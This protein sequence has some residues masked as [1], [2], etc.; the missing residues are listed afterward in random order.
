MNLLEEVH[1]RAMNI[2]RGLELLSCEDSL[3]IRVT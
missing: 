1:K 3:R 2:I